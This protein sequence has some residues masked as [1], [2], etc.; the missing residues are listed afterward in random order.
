MRL[1]TAFVEVYG[2][3]TERDKRDPLNDFPL[4][5]DM[6]LDEDSDLTLADTLPDPAAETAFDALALRI[7]V[8]NALAAL[9]PDER[10]AIIGEFWHGQRADAKTRS[11]ALRHL[12]HPTV[13]RNLKVYLS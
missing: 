6:P 1:K 8:Q 5:L 10:R 12:R 13:S 4:A 11:S 2:L 7:A 3:R 9:P